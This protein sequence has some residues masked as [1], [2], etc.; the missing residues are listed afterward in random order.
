M[1]VEPLPWWVGVA[2]A[3]AEI[4]CDGA[5]HRLVWARGEV[6]PLDHPDPDADRALVALGGESPACLD[7]IRAWNEHAST[8][9]LVT[10]GRRPGE[11]GLGLAPSA[12]RAHAAASARTQRMLGAAR[13]RVEERLRR[14]EALTL[15]L[16]LPA[17]FI[18]R[19][20]LGVFASA[21]ERWDDESFRADH[22]LRIGAALSTRATPALRRF[23]DR[24]GCGPCDVGVSPARPGH[25]EPVVA[26]RLE[27]GQ[28]VVIS[29]DLPVRWIT[30]VWGRGLSEPDGELVLDVV[31]G[32]HDGSAFE[33]FVAEWE[34][35]G[36]I[37]WEAAPVPATVT[38]DDDGIRR[39]QRHW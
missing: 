8:P 20:V 33:V 31:S 11:Q 39:V 3:E 22:G 29:A 35:A 4:E 10:L 28:P 25:G 38:V 12:V 6:R 17:P 7:V 15:L 1:T 19:L 13:E 14:R 27:S 36:P 30:N 9:E 5:S 24:L 34:P 21:A 26:A 23:G 37:T 2:P 16:S 32:E 18:D